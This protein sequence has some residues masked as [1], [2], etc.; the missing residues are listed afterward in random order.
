MV[1]GYWR[2]ALGAVLACALIGL[3]NMKPVHANSCPNGYLQVAHAWSL[4]TIRA[5][6]PDLARE[7]E[8][9][10][11]AAQ[12]RNSYQA[13]ALP[14]YRPDAVS[15]TVGPRLRNEIRT[16]APINAD[17][18]FRY[19]DPHTG[20]FVQEIG[21]IRLSGGIGSIWMPGDPRQYVRESFWPGIF[22]SPVPSGGVSRLRSFPGERLGCED[23]IHGIVP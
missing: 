18:P 12:A 8:D 4:T 11:R 19:L 10:I 20:Q 17:L 2:I 15:R 3:A 22:E 13:T 16:H 5:M 14:P 6:R 9:L 21:T 7:I 23:N 1:R